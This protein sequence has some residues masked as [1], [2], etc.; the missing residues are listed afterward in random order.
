MQEEWY[1]PSKMDKLRAAAFS[2]TPAGKKFNED[3]HEKNMRCIH[4][5]VKNEG[6]V[7]PFYE[8]KSYEEWLAKHPELYKRRHK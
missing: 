4:W 1:I 5:R 6:F 8:K 7:P 2:A 3:Q